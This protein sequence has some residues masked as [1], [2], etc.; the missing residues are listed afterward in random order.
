MLNILK[1]I[2][3]A[4][5]GI[6]LRV[7][8]VCLLLPLFSLLLAS[9]NGGLFSNANWQASGLQGQ[10]LRVLEVSSKDSNTLY[11]GNV[12][13]NIFTST[14]A[15][16]KW[17][18]QSSGLPLP[19]TIHA[20]SFDPGGQKLYATTEKGL[21]TKM[22]GATVWQK[23]TTASLPSTPFTALTFLSDAPHVIYVG[24]SGQGIF[25]SH[26]DGT[27]W[28][29][30]NNGLP[31]RVAVNDLSFD[32]V[33][34]QLW[35]ATS[36]GAYR[37]DTRGTSWHSFNNGL[38]PSASVN[39][40]VPDTVNGSA[41]RLLYI[42]TTHGI[43]L[44]HDSGAHWTTNSEA[45]SNINIHRILIDFRSPNGNAIYV[46]TSIGVFSSTDSGQNWGSVATGLPT[47]V[48]VYALAIGATNNAQI[49]AAG[50]GLYAFPGTGSSIDPT[51]IFTYL[52]IAAFFFLLY[53]LGM[54]GRQ[55][56]RRMLKPTHSQ[57]TPISTPT[58]STGL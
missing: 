15:G 21:F 44:S 43:F 41:Q 14:N 30:A 56:G 47:N 18:E 38:P 11:V 34:N 6:L 49:Y 26:D 17:T 32:P 28:L 9:C 42:G 4:K 55:A 3:P 27:S 57:G 54:R 23:I 48:A 13:G 33:Q 10:Q 22:E 7:L 40:I 25:V 24:T 58:D 45:L 51:R 1:E 37:S 53:R 5:T 12:Q 29:A 19:D 16:Q 31:Q 8:E 35:A 2:Y 20:L 39:T 36:A 52:L 50:N 46:A